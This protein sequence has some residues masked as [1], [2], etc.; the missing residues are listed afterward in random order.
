MPFQPSFVAMMVAK[1][2]A[3][4]LFYGEGMVDQ[5]VYIAL[6]SSA[7][8]IISFRVGKRDGENTDLFARDLRERVINAPEISTD[9]WPSYGPAIR[10]AF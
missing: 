2:F 3:D 6:A 8:A 4:Y 5:Y 9:G 10:V 7:K 1:K